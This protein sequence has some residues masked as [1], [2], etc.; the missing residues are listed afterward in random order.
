MAALVNS[1]YGL[2]VSVHDQIAAGLTEALRQ[3]PAPG[4]ALLAAVRQEGIRQAV[5]R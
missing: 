1:N 2:D 5:A 4:H 3:R